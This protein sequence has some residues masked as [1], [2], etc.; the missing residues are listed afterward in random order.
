MC[1][2]NNKYY[3]KPKREENFYYAPGGNM[4]SNGGESFMW[5]FDTLRE[6]HSMILY[7]A[8]L[9]RGHHTLSFLV[10]AT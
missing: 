2:A 8:C 10:P 3:G 1:D 7:R 4:G 9:V 5:S 6:I